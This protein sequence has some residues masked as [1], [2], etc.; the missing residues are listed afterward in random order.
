MSINQTLYEIIVPIWQLHRGQTR[1]L[2]LV[3]CVLGI[4]PYGFLKQRRVGEY[5]LRLDPG[6]PNDLHYY[7]QKVGAGYQFLMKLLLVPGDCVIDVGVNVGYFSAVCAQCVGFKGEVYAI[8]ASPI[9]FERFRQCVAEVAGGPIRVYH[10]A[11][12]RSSG[13]VAFNVATNSGWSSMRENATF[14]TLAIVQVPA[15][16]LDD[17]VFRENIQ[18]VRVLKLD[19]EGAETDALVGAP[20]LLKSGIVD[21]ILVEAEPNRLKAFGH[22]GQ[23]LACLFEQNGYRPVCM[24]EN[25]AVIPLTEDRRVPGSSNCD[26]LY[27]QDKLYQSTVA[28]LFKGR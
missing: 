16:T 17:F 12:W 26:Y 28:L 2:N 27:A 14:E 7:F 8:E 3:A 15:I 23:D 10:S 19:I 9:M 22:T 25:D 21:Y 4:K 11:V 13:E 18:R 24:I 5:K 6:D 1:W 20:T